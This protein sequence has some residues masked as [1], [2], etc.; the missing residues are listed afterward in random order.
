MN[1][2]L[3]RFV[4]TG[5][6]ALSVGAPAAL[7]DSASIGTTGPGSHNQIFS[8][9]RNSFSSVMVNRVNSGNVNN[10]SASTGGEGIFGNTAVWGAGVSSGSAANWNSGQNNVFISNNDNG[11]NWVG[12]GKG[13]GN[14]TIFLTGPHSSNQIRTDNSSRVS[15]TTVNTVNAQNFSNQA[16]RSGSVTVAGNT[17]VSGAGGSGNA[18]NENSGVNNVQ[19]DNSSAMPAGFVGDNGG[20][21]ATIGITGPHSNN[22]IFENSSQSFNS[23]T[24]NSV[25]A[26]NFNQQSASTGNVK[27][28]NN[29]VASGAN[30]SGSATNSNMAQNN[31]GISN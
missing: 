18:V 22:Q 6:V 8:S 5:A 30:G 23:K 31:V 2:L 15:E 21:S 17:L 28:A 4:A 14:T 20:G 11:G 16:A 19:I 13:G 1:K 9:N 25:S 3:V 12:L 24:I 29:T 10:Q 27:I 7:A 26:Q